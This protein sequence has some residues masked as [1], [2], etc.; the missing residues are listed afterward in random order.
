MKNFLSLLLVL[1]PIFCFS[2]E[3]TKLLR[4]PTVHGNQIV[5][6]YAGDLY[7]VSTNGGTA[8]RLTSHNGFEMFAKFSPNGKNIAFTGQYNGNTE[9]YIMPAKGGAPERLTYTATLERDEISDRMGPNNIVINW[10]PDGES[11]VYRSRKQS[12]NSFVGQLFTVSKSGGLSEEVPLSTGGFC[13][14]SP[15]GSQLAFNRVFREFRT[16]KYY[17]GGMADDI[18]IYQLNSDSIKNITNNDAQNIIPMW[19]KN[20]I[21]FA[22]DRDRTMNIFYY[23]TETKE[24]KKVTTF[25]NYDV[26][27]P[28]IGGNTIVFENEGSIY[29]LNTETL[30]YNKVIINIATDYQINNVLVDAS[31]FIHSSD[32]S[33]DGKRV[34]FGSRGDIF[35]VP[36]K[37]GV[38]YN[39]TNSAN[40]NDRQSVYAP[41]GKKIAFISDQDGEFEIYLLDLEN[42]NALIQL[43]KNTGLYKYNLQWSPDSKKILYNDNKF[44][45]FALD[46]EQKK[47]DLIDKSDAGIFRSFNWAPDSKWIAYSKSL[48]NLYNTIFLYNTE[49]KEKI[50]VTE[51]WYSSNRP[52]F[53]DDGNF[54]IFTSNRDFNP[55]WNDIE[56]NHA[57]KDMTKLY[58]VPL[59][60]KTISPFAYKNDMVN[61][62]STNEEDKDSKIEINP[63]NIQEKI[64][65]FPVEKG[66]YWNIQIADQKIYYTY[67][68]HSAKDRD[69]KL[70]DLSTKKEKSIGEN[71]SYQISDNNKKMLVSKSSNYYIVDLPG[72]TVKFENK[73]NTND[74]SLIIDKSVEWAQIFHESWRQI[75]DL[76]YARNMHG[77]DWELIKQKYEVF[78]PFI[79]HR[80]DLS[81]IIG[82]MIG[83]LSIG[84]AYIG[85]GDL[86]EVKKVKL[87]LLGAKIEKDNSGYFKITKIFEGANWDKKLRSPLTECQPQLNEGD[88]IIA[89]N[90]IKTNQV[91]DLYSLL[92]DKA[93]K[94]I[95]LTYNSKASDQDVTK[96]I[97]KP[98][99]DESELYY[100]NWIHNNIKK[101]EKATDGKVGYIHLPDMVSYGL[102]QFARLYYAQLNKKALIIDNRGNG[103]GN[104]S[105]MIIER[106]KRTPDYYTMRGDATWGHPS[107]GGLIN[108]PKVMIV[109]EYCASDGDLVAYRFRQ[110]KLGKLIGTRTWGGVVGI[111]GSLQF[112]D[113]TDLRIPILAPF[114]LDGKEFII[115][116]YGVDPDIFIDN[117]PAKE[118]NNEDTQLN[119]AIEYILLELKTKE[120]TVPNAPAFPDKT[121]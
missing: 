103:G 118:Y 56:W 71:F 52:T 101:V 87:G 12:F 19:Y 16:W 55:I 78:L 98:I 18:W 47:N 110:N 8:A 74:M 88:F 25:D 102:N 100:Y 10:T 42:N 31:K 65:S 21:F 7:K 82:E 83:E 76:F 46:V 13:S 66:Y 89:I 108:G 36:A 51:G 44:R 93:G 116:G 5:F 63:Q 77:L 17:K 75:R 48:R 20:K 34:I 80:A 3:E 2:Q 11:I 115:E 81:Y 109:N 79:N 70:F 120:I 59:N 94:N 99:A 6:T 45:L 121:K 114:S 27:F 58:I 39:Y 112:V 117:N 32:I 91:K 30:E 38:T 14:Y 57:F 41:D 105:P 104:V 85:K 35:S 84:H 107:P 73:V 69:V 106:L 90:G 111:G 92:I 40:A 53:T 28:S 95:E 113:G 4:F 29:T 62:K 26:K 119:K 86:P 23:D 1:L 22:S 97:I 49:T 68:T 61:E 60:E 54:L 15:D 50:Q 24:T 33:A 64:Q 37:E 72:S 67:S 96:A 9:V 43:T